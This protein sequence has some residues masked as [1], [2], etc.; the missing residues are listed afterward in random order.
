MMYHKKWG[1]TLEHGFT[2]RDSF[3]G[4]MERQKKLVKIQE[5]RTL[6][7]EVYLPFV[8]SKM[9]GKKRKKGRT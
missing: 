1:F 4:E 7:E 8:A 2:D 6:E 5:Q 9:A 3:L